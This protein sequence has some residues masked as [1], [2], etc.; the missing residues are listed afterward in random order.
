MRWRSS[1]VAISPS[2]VSSD[3]E[4]TSVDM[5][6]STRRPCDLANSP[7]RVDGRGHGFEPPGTPLFGADLLAMEEVRLADHADDIVVVIDHGQRA[8]VMLGEKPHR[9]RNI[10]VRA[11]R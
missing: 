9:H 6:S 5:T 2:G 10:I 3:A 8:D 7:A 11:L 1:S 4:T